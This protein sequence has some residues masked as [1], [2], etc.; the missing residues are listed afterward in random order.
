MAVGDNCYKNDN[1]KKDNSLK[2]FSAIFLEKKNEMIRR[3]ILGNTIRPLYTKSISSRSVEIA[4]L[5][6]NAGKLKG[7]ALKETIGAFMEEG[8][9][10]ASLIYSIRMINTDSTI[11]QIIRQI[12]DHLIT[13]SDEAHNYNLEAILSAAAQSWSNAQLALLI[14]QTSKRRRERNI[15]TS[16]E[17]LVN[18]LVDESYDFTPGSATHSQKLHNLL[19]FISE[20]CEIK[21]LSNEVVVMLATGLSDHVKKDELSNEVEK[22]LHKTI[23]LLIGRIIE[24][25][26]FAEQLKTI[27]LLETCVEFDVNDFKQVI[28]STMTNNTVPILTFLEKYAKAERSSS[29][30]YE[31]AATLVELGYGKEEEKAQHTS[32]H[33][34]PSEV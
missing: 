12:A 27:A 10:I 28:N 13:K 1:S 26:S 25:T 33:L 4:R 23:D 8:V 31:L 34:G 24:Y 32:G 7:D 22:E 16:P 17:E 30:S 29:S 19:G 2:D 3:E 21:N 18:I 5:V 14:D 6:S 20:V 9:G 11:V 15:T